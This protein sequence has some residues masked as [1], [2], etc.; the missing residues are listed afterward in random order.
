[1]T[2]S[3]TIWWE[4]G[5]F[6]GS[7]LVFFV[8]AEEASSILNRVWLGR[9]ET[10]IESIDFFWFLFLKALIPYEVRSIRNDN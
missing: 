8:K 5:I 9:K 3:V 2:A 10:K 4:L 7:V 1:M 6:F